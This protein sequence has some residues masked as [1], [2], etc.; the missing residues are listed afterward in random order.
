MVSLIL[1]P[2]VDVLLIPVPLANLAIRLPHSAQHLDNRLVLVA[3]QVPDGGPGDLPVV[4][5]VSI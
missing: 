5:P 1:L 2:E 3:L 4:L